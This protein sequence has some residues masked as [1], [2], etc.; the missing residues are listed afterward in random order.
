MIKG[1]TMTVLQER[2]LQRDEAYTHIHTSPP[3]SHGE[4]PTSSLGELGDLA[5]KY[6]WKR[7][8]IRQARVRHGD[9]NTELPG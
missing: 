1:V 5:F 4:A 8:Y 6:I 9:Q 7:D 2:G 3:R